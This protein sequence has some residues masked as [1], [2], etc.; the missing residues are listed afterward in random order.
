MRTLTGRSHCGA[1]SSDS[2]SSFQGCNVMDGIRSLASFFPSQKAAMGYRSG[3]AV[4]E[5][6]HWP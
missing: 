2:G 3:L 4:N 5:V 1:Y 6:V